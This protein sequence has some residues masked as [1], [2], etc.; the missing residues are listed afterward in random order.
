MV[1]SNDQKALGTSYQQYKDKGD[2]LLLEDENGMA[3]YL[4][5]ED[6]K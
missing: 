2:I 5:A 4:F 6:L 3:D 1:L